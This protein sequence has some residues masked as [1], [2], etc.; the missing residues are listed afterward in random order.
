MRLDIYGQ[1]VVSVVKPDGGWSKGRPIAFIE[2][3]DAW[4]LAD[5]LIPNGLSEPAL[6]Q[7]VAD[8]FSNFAWAG[9]AIRRLD[10]RPST[11]LAVR[12]ARGHMSK[13]DGSRHYAAST[14]PWPV[15][16]WVLPMFWLVVLLL[17]S[18]LWI[19]S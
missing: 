6:E 15:G 13:D 17:A 2:E 5:L 8:K 12:F 19:A 14:W 3:Q 18:V 11:S 4:R 16:G 9:R 10:V 7:Y 1:F